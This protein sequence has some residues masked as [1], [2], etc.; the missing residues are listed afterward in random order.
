MLRFVGDGDQKKFTKNP[1]RFS[2]AKLPG[3]HEKKKNHKPLLEIRQS[4]FFVSALHSCDGSGHLLEHGKERKP[5]YVGAPTWREVNAAK[6]ATEITP[7]IFSGYFSPQKV[8]LIF[9]VF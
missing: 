2:I 6:V 7:R 5:K 9:R 3:K 1:R 8:I 4:N